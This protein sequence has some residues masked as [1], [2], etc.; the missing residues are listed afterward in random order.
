MT[1]KSQTSVAKPKKNAK[2]PSFLTRHPYV[3]PVTTFIVLFFVGLL[4]FVMLGASTQGA[5]D[6]RIVNV[7]VDGEQ[8]TVTTRAKDVGELLQRLQIPMVEQDIVEPAK[9]FLILEDNTQINIYRARPVEVLDG[10]RVVT[11]FTAQRAPRLVAAEAGIELVPEDEATF[12][13]TDTTV[14]ESSA[15]EQLVVDRS[16]EVQF[17]Q[18]GVLRSVRTTAD[19]VDAFLKNEG[20]VL[21]TGETVQ[22]EL[23]S[24]ITTGLLVSVNKPGIKTATV[25]ESIP[26]AVEKK[27]DPEL[28]AG[29]S[30]V[31]QAGVAGE[32]AVIYEIVEENG[33]EISRREIQQVTVRQPVNEVVVRGTKIVSPAFSSTETVAG[34]K[35]A[36]MAAAGISE[37]D[38]GYVD[39]IVSKESRWRPG[40]ANSSS[41]A[42]GLCQALPAS[43]MASA[44]GDY[45]T[46]PVTQ[47]QW[48]SGYAAG[49]YGGWAGAYSA[50]QVQGWW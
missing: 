46:N 17:N 13:R 27:D 7:F 19:S 26:F 45:L 16:V 28:K 41:G 42:Y 6:A 9:D 24:S 37:A 36:L 32:R 15:S 29:E 4:S 20:V 22:P 43:K 49:R 18:Y 14:L 25:T 23:Q 47:L 3:I 12:E 5:T 21:Q 39:Y 48:C 30:S 31:A 44:G 33:V 40:V 50:W 2:K 8:R 38:F 35:A 1:K 10:N 34:D 11:V